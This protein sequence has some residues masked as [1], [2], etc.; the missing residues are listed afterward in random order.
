MITRIEADGFKS[1]RGFAVDLEPLTA[2]VGVN[3]TGKSNL[4]EALQVLSGLPAMGVVDALHAAGRGTARDMFSRTADDSAR[5]MRLAVELLLPAACGGPRPLRHTRFRYEIVLERSASAAG[6]ES[7]FLHHEHLTAIAQREDTWIAGHPSFAPMALYGAEGFYAKLD[8]EASPVSASQRTL[9]WPP[10]SSLTMGTRGKESSV[11]SFPSGLG[12]EFLDEVG[13][14]LRRFRFLHL[15]VSRLR[16]PSD[17]AASTGRASDGANLPTALAAL[18]PALRAEIR[19]DLATMIPSFRSFDV[20]PVGDYFSIE[21]EFTDGLRFP[22][23]VLSDGTLRFLALF[24]VVRSSPPGTIIVLEEP[25]NGIHPGSLRELMCALLEATKPH[26][27]LPPQVLVAS[28]SP[29]V[30]AALHAQPECLVLADLVR[31][32]DGL[33]STRMRHVWREGAPKDRG[34]T[35]ASA[36]E[37]E[38]YLETA[39]PPVE[40]Q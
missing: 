13:D 17:P 18:S 9:R 5:Q 23:R 30:V 39:R 1:L 8:P 21:V 32:G 15:E 36:R 35:T 24:T 12:P 20:I 3:G 27:D 7:I 31:R 14:E 28:H 2:I 29:A 25:E 4:F 10:S 22:A 6:V 34:A 16:Q 40:D 33:L 38:R 37:V 11:L 26:R 19:A